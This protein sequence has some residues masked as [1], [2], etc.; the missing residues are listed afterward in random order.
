MNTKIKKNP[1]TAWRKYDENALLI[2]P[3]DS[4]I[5]KLNE[6]ATFIWEM[7]QD[8]TLSINEIAQEIVNEFEVSIEIA[9]KDIKNIINKMAKKQIVF[10][11]K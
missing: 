9:E 2:T 7:L 1:R 3:D 8:K 11:E 6:T 5:H 4:K 10:K